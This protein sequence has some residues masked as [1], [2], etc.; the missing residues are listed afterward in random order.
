MDSLGI[1]ILNYL[2]Y[3]DTIECLDTLLL[4]TKKDIPTVIVDNNSYNE[5]YAKIKQYVTGKRNFYLIKAHENLGFSKG[6][7]LGIFFLKTKFSVENILICNNDLIFKNTNY[8]EKLMELDIDDSN[9]GAI[10]TAIIGK[11]LENQNPASWPFSKEAISSE[12]ESYSLQERNDIFSKDRV[13]ETIPYLYLFFKYIKDLLLCMRNYI[14]NGRDLKKKPV[15]LGR[16]SYLHGSAFILTKNYFE[17]F[18]CLY[19]KTFLYGEEKILKILF[20]KVGLSMLYVSNL[21]IEHKE[22]KSSALSFSNVNQIGQKYRKDSNE[23]ILKMYDK[24]I[25][26]ILSDFGDDS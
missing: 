26:D 17:L 9:I 1:V 24:N 7:N 13:K 16:K 19:P 3:E 11:N 25:K 8:L 23:V 21:S 6:N 20:D 22:D 5:S 15:I 12:I 4:Q 10:G 2:N 14:K 18:P